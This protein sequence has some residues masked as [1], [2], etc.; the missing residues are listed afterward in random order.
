MFELNPD[1][2]IIAPNGVDLE[3]FVSLPDP[4]TARRQL[5]FTEASTV[6]CTGHLYAGRGVELFIELARRIPSA[7]F[8][9]VGGRLQDVNEWRAKASSQ[10]LR[11][12]LF[13]GFIP[14]R[15]LPLYQSGADILLMPYARSI[16]GSSGS[17][18]S[19]A[20]ASPMK[21]F[22]YMAAERAIITSD[23]PVIREVLNES[24]ALFCPPDDVDAWRT[25]LENLLAYKPRRLMFARQARL[26]VE[27]H[28]WIAR[29]R[30][31]LDGF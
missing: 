24:N 17:A 13:T 21:M 9:W 26:A 20:V 5:N 23:L 7:Q 28:T 29:A 2:V 25:A 15:D 12:V 19:G 6:M 27:N 30:H 22:E 1:E 4:V 16:F 10:N 18:D 11:N 14:N 8:V 31:V 3:R